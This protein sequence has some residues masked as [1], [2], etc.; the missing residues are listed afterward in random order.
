MPRGQAAFLGR[1]DDGRPRALDLASAA[2]FRA[3]PAAEG[4][5]RAAVR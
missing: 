4:L 5:C 1:T 3:Q 2:P